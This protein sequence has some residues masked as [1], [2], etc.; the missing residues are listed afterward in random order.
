MQQKAGKPGC[1]VVC[2]TIGFAAAAAAGGLAL[3]SRRIRTFLA[4]ATGKLVMK[5]AG[6]CGFAAAGI[7]CSSKC[8]VFD[9][10]PPPPPMSPLSPWLMRH[11]PWPR[12]D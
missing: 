5:V 3:W 9:V 2:S 7:Y 11:F 10:P 6:V 8:G 4:G 1:V 12:Y